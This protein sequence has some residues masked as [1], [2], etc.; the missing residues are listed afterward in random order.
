MTRMSLRNQAKS[1]VR[2][3]LGQFG[4]HLKSIGRPMDPMSFGALKAML[5]YRI[6]ILE[7]ISA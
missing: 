6:G 4:R 3:V 5:K 7:K 1:D 2:N